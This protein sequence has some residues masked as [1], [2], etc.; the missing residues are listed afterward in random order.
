MNTEVVK[1]SGAGVVLATMVVAAVVAVWVSNGVTSVE[2]LSYL[3]Y[4]A[5]AI[6]LPGMVVVRAAYR[7]NP[8]G[9]ALVCLGVPVGMALQ[10]VGFVL[11]ASLG[12]HRLAW[13]VAPAVGVV[14]CLA[15]VWRRGVAVLR[16]RFVRAPFLEPVLIGILCLSS[17]TLLALRDFPQHPLPRQASSEGLAYYRDMPW[18]LGNLSAA[19]RDWP[20]E[21]PRISGEPLHYHVG[22]YV[23]GA[24]TSTVTGIDVATLLF[25]L[26]PVMVLLLLG[27]QVVWVGRQCGGPGLVGVVAA[28]LILLTGDAASLWR[29]TSSQ[30]FNLFLTHFYL[31]P[32]FSLGL[33][34]FLPALALAGRVIAGN[35][36]RQ[37]GDVMLGLLLLPACGLTK[38]TTLPVLAAAA[39]GVGGLHLL[40]RRE[41][42]KPALLVAAM[43]A[44]VFVVVWPVVIP[45]SADEVKTMTWNP[46]GTFRLTPMWKALRTEMSTGA[47][48]L[49]VAL[50]HAPAMLAG[51]IAFAVTRRSWAPM[52]IWLAMVALAGAG[53]AL[54]FTATGNGQLYFWFNGYVA[55][56]VLA[57]VGLVECLRRP[58]TVAAHVIRVAAVIAV[59]IATLSVVFQSR[60]GVKRLM[61]NHFRMFQANPDNQVPDRPAE[62]TRG[63]VEGLRWVA[64]HT[65]PAA[66]IAV[67][68]QTVNFYY[69][70]LTERAVY[71]EKI[72]GVVDV[73]ARTTLAE[74]ERTVGRLF[75]DAGPEES[76]AAATAAGVSYL[77]NI[78]PAGRPTLQLPESDRHRVVFDSPEV[79][80]LSLAACPG[81]ADTA[82]GVQLHAWTR[83]Q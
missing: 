6:A 55:A 66:V 81:G 30:F 63:M 10:I 65:D 1:I 19:K 25:R 4:W 47:M 73:F 18:H 54:L 9:L 61:G 31:S 75:G 38:S 80:V 33:V 59:V 52:H 24:G 43:V 36:P 42:H 14:A 44:V 3:L 51:I 67:N 53:P 82:F 26:D 64:R 32:T 62:L 29:Q 58:P 45:P 68:D 21:N 56:G 11:V 12:F 60:P 50:G 2:A 40:R 71:L 46:L 34:L 23:F 37:R 20:L 78:K 35:H 48:T 8:G 17:V 15:L 83:W 27:A 16:V 70:A 49:I 74:R 39:L 79:S 72:A 5:L 41:L 57:A 28:Y 77:V 69:S 76:C 7:D 13:F 22:A